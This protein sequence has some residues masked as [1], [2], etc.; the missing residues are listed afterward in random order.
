MLSFDTPDGFVAIAHVPAPHPDAQTMA[1]GPL[2]PD[3]QAIAASPAHLIV[4]VSGPDGDAQVR[5][6]VLLRALAAAIAGG[7]AIAAMV[8]HGVVF[9]KA[10]VLSELVAAAAE[11]DQLP[12]EVAID[13]TAARESDTRMSFLTHGMA[14]YGRE[15]FYVTCPIRGKGALDFVYG[16]VR[17][18]LTDPDKQLP[19]GDTVGRSAEERLVIHRV[20]SPI[21]ASVQV[22]R[23][24]LP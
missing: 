5:D 13:V 3:A 9:H 12:C 1:R 15:D 24:D 16:M 19:T 23:L 7:D 11:D 14:R 18:M 21:D 6:G 2:S 8:G 17:W 20:A 4:T 10:E 22:I